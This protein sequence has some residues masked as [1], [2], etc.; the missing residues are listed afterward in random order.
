[1]QKILVITILLILLLSSYLLIKSNYEKNEIINQSI[2]RKNEVVYWKDRFQ[3]EHATV[4][5]IKIQNDKLMNE[6]VASLAKTLSVKP[7]NINSVSK[8]TTETKTP[9]IYIY[10]TFY[11]DPYIDIRIIRD[12]VRMT[13]FDTLTK[14]EYSKRKNIFGK[15]RNYTDISNTNKYVKIKEPITIE[16]GSTRSPKFIIGPSLTWDFINNRYTPGI[17][18]LFY[19]VSIKL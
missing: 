4:E 11:K 17:S 12:S 6:K 10:D 2:D 8:F 18:I 13:L 15:K 1:M 7:K 5:R 19:P 9:P 3:K 16:R 14:T